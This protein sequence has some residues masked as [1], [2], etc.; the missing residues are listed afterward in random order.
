MDNRTF[1][2]K[3]YNDRKKYNSVK[4]TQ[5]RKKN[6]L[7]MWIADM[8][9]RPDERIVKALNDFISYGDYGYA[10]LPND[11]YDT[12]IAWN[13]KRNNITLKAE[14]I[15]FSKGAIDGLY[16]VIY[17]L[18]N[19]KDGIM[20]NTPVYHPFK[21]TIKETNRTVVES[22]LINND[23][24]FTFDYKDIE[25]KFKT[26]KVKAIILCSPHNPIGRVWKKGELE[27][28]LDLCHKYKVLVISDEVHSD[29]IMP[30]QEFIPTMAF[31]KYI[32]DVVTF[33]AV[34]KT[35]SFP[36]YQNCHVVIANKKLRDKFD[37]YQ[38]HEH[39]SSVNVFNALST[40]YGYKYGE[41]W[42]D[43]VNNII[44]E[45][46]NYFKSKLS[47]YYE[48]SVLEGTYLIFVNIGEH[49][50]DKCAAN[51]LIEKCHIMTNAGGVFGGR[52]YDKW[53][54]INLATS[55][56]NVKKAVKE[57]EKIAK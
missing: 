30:D 41:Q 35:F 45:N 13:K 50:K 19:P 4:W 43:T 26:N 20:I 28:L 27:E 11:Y 3:Y 21:A 31:K 10:D 7:P 6:C 29:L 17:A 2:K 33:T 16:Q 8:D 37:A 36:L 24:Y 39:R 47:K 51:Y 46:Y 38:K 48:I 1:E 22:P 42:L 57:L 56:T 12:L 55:L 40:Y 32:N 9:F 52:K 14:W 5:A 18:T 53:V 44:F 25:T 23:G 49:S 54:R 15:R 34:S